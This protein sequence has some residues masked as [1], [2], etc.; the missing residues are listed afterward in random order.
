VDPRQ[1]FASA[2]YAFGEDGVERAGVGRAPSAFRIWRAGGNPTDMG[3]HVFTEE[4]ARLLMAQQEIRGNLYSIDVDHL[5]LDKI[6]PPES[7]KAV[8][9][10]GLAVRP[11]ESG[12]E[13]WAVNVK[14]TEAVRGGL[15]MDP[16]EW[17]YF[18]P[19]YKTDPK[20]NEIVA[21]LNT[22]L[23]NNPAT[24]SVTELATLQAATATR[25]SMDYKEMA[26]AFFGKDDEKKQ[27]AKECYS[28][29]SESERKA[30]KAA[31]KAAEE[32]WGDEKKPT[33]GETRETAESPEED[34]KKKKDEEAKKAAVA[35]EEKKKSDEAAA[36]MA[37]SA[38]TLA[39]EVQDLKV[40]KA[41][42]EAADARKTETDQRATILAKR[43][44]LSDAQ[45]AVFAFVPVDKLQAHLDALP[46]VTSSVRATVNATTPTA[47]GGERQDSAGEPLSE[48]QHA[49]LDKVANAGGK[50]QKAGLLRGT[51]FSVPVYD[52]SA[53]R[54]RVKELDDAK[55]KN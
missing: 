7:R 23:T 43:P 36:T 42:R 30:F 1:V 25:D 51:E 44:D 50:S 37:A 47:T 14:W 13:L 33:E 28:K 40:W 39:K 52:P 12:P 15:E 38:L 8:G 49:I 9:W 45:R 53:V 2:T 3:V 35:A 31:W 55:A 19:A 34:E 24:H 11:S 20:T 17:R 32:G 48:E 6:A 26:A 46:R 22:A 21:Y 41:Q 27:S 54:A 4:S 5:S 29:M 16:P 18:S 10:N